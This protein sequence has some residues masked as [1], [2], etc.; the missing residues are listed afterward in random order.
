MSVQ[1]QA[2]PPPRAVSVAPTPR[3]RRRG[4]SRE[5]KRRKGEQR[6][7]HAEG[8]DASPSSRRKLD[9]FSPKKLLLTF[10]FVTLFPKHRTQNM[11]HIVVILF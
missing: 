1:P 2:P 7:H 6:A 8:R 9:F 3:R 5:R 11:S 10:P 4:E